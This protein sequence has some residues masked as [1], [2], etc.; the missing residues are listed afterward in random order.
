MQSPPLHHRDYYDETEEQRRRTERDLAGTEL[1]LLEAS[2]VGLGGGALWAAGTGEKLLRRTMARLP[3]LAGLACLA[4]AVAG[5]LAATGLWTARSTVRNWDIH[6][7]IVF[8]GASSFAS[9]L[10]LL[11]KPKTNEL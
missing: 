8:P 1:S 6:H 2:L 4:G 7:H 9:L 3:Q 5:A 10:S 11:F